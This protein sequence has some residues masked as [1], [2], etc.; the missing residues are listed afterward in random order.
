MQRTG[1]RFYLIMQGIAITHWSAAQFVISHYLAFAWLFECMLMHANAFFYLHVVSIYLHELVGHSNGSIKCQ[2]LDCHWNTRNQNCN[3]MS[4]FI[5]SCTLK[6]TFSAVQ[7][8]HY[9]VMVFIYC[10]LSFCSDAAGNEHSCWNSSR[11]FN[12]Q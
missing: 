12:F 2:M 1:F 9:I 3:A 7:C 10:L 6:H 8:F 5:T 4:S 11:T